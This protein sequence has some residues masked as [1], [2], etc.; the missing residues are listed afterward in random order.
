VPEHLRWSEFTDFSGGLW[1][2]GVSPLAI[3]ANAAQEMLDCHPAPG[4]GLAAAHYVPGLTYDTSVFGL[5]PVNRVHLNEDAD[6][7]R[8][9]YAA[10]VD[11]RIY[12]GVNSLGNL[13]WQLLKT[14]PSGSNVYF[15]SYKDSNDTLMTAIVFNTTIGSDRGLWWDHMDGSPLTRG[16]DD[17][18]QNVNFRGPLAVHQGRLVG[19]NG[20]A[21]GPSQL[22]WTDVGG[23][24]WVTD[25]YLDI[26]R[27]QEAHILSLTPR[28]PSDLVI[29]TKTHWHLVQGDLSAPL[30]RTGEWEGTSSTFTP[31]SFDGGIAYAVHGRGI[32]LTADGMQHE[33]LSPQISSSSF[34]PNRTIG[35]LQYAGKLLFTPGGYVYDTASGAWFRS[36]DVALQGVVKSQGVVN[37]AGVDYFLAVSQTTPAVMKQIWVRQSGNFAAEMHW[38]SPPLS[39][40]GRQVEVREVQVNFGAGGGGTLSVGVGGTVKALAVPPSN[41][42]LHRFV[43][44]ERG[45]LLSTR[46]SWEG[47]TVG[48]A[49]NPAT[50][51]AVRI[52]WLPGHRINVNTN[53]STIST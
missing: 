12:R 43:F 7:T 10:L 14:G 40:P 50:V 38:R 19:R 37:S 4:G 34:T 23:T 1:Q 9:T 47:D 48:G 26:G 18:G 24:T 22:I 39:A 17:V 49:P 36:Q 31:V 33:H 6:G 29:S 21:G 35:D 52:G 45:K 32:W 28:P 41:Q 51:Q 20:G 30:Q 2:G 15:A 53:I 16:S 3:P 44:R 8:Y 13:N 25:N 27:R 46:V 42:A 11:G 5:T